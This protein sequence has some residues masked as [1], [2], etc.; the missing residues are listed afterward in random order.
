[1]RVRGTC[2]I[3]HVNMSYVLSIRTELITDGGHD[4]RRGKRTNYV[5]ICVLCA[6]CCV[7]CAACCVVCAVYVWTRH[8]SSRLIHADQHHTSSTHTETRDR[9][10]YIAPSSFFLACAAHAHRH[11][12]PHACAHVSERAGVTECSASDTREAAQNGQRTARHDGCTC[13]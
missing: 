12:H 5:G 7:L 9:P 11:T 3:T 2:H 13:T 8:V 6:V 1:M 4:E 10:L